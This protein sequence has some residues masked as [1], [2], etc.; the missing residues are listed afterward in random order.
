MRLVGAGDDP[1]HWD[2]HGHFF[3]AAAEAMRR[4][5][6]ENARRKQSLKHGG[7]HGELHVWRDGDSLVCEVSD[8]GHITSPLVGRIP[9]ALSQGFGAGLWLANQL[10]DLVQICSSANGTAI[11]VYQHL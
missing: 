6:V 7:G 4:I 10:C 9:P 3:A 8:Q 1:P 2:N 11:R 5:L